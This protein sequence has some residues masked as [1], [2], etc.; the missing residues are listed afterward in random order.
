MKPEAMDDFARK[1]YCLLGIPIDD[2]TMDCLVDRIVQSASTR[3]RL[4]FSTP[5]LNFLILSQHDREFRRSLLA[6]DICCVDGIGVLL[7][8]RLLGV[9]I[10]SRVA[11]S[12]IPDAIR[13]NSSRF[14]DRPVSLTFFGGES[15]VG[16]RACRAVNE[17]QQDRL[18]CVGAID[19]GVMD[20]SKISNQ[21][22]LDSLNSTG[23]DFLLVAL[24]AQKG[25]AWLMHNMKSLK[26]PVMS[27][28]GATLNFLAGTVKRAPLTVRRLG[29]EWF[30]RVKEEPRLA[31]R[32]ISDGAQISLLIV[33]RIIPLS[34]WLNWNRI[35][36]R[37]VAPT[38]QV[39]VD[40]TNFT[41]IKVAGG[42]PDSELLSIATAFR[43][44]LLLG[45]P[46]V[47][48]LADLRFFEMGFAG[49]I[50]MLERSAQTQNQSFVIEGATATV[51][52]VLNWCGLKH[53]TG[54]F[55]YRR[56]VLSP[57][58]GPTTP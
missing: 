30:W 40:E 29:L 54:K 47:L 14:L 4:F 43:N 31:S 26:I 32:Y 34:V 2:I 48:D 9:P 13:A 52:Q 46:I 6:S 37:K 42:A 18:V 49:Y 39:G 33:T 53:L 21:V 36:R 50:L 56:T 15:G 38:I 27:H 5:N 8:C 20:A 11:G 28:L 16:E 44:A 35:F 7:L 1:V 3:S 45:N 51:G 55:D 22:M 10:K 25:Q 58:S 19:P 17:S 23:A 57:F 24:G 12:D 41:R